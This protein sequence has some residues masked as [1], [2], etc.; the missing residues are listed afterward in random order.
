MTKLEM[1]RQISLIIM[2]YEAEHRE[3]VGVEISTSTLSDSV[4]HDHK[5]EFYYWNGEAFKEAQLPE[6]E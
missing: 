5:H 3:I 4:S 1:L 6:K 2:K